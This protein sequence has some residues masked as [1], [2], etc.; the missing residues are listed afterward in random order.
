MEYR[1]FYAHLKENALPA[2]LL[3]HGEEEYIKESALKQ[4]RAAMLPEGLEVMNEVVFEG[5]AEENAIIEA[6]ET[7][8]FMAEK[9]LVLVRDHP[10][11]RN[12]QGGGGDGSRL[13][14]YLANMPD[15]AMLVFYVRG[16]A[17]M[18]RKVP[19][20]VA[21]AGGVVVFK[22]LEDRELFAFLGRECQRQGASLERG[23]AERLVFLCGRDLTVLSRE[24]EKAVAHAQDGKV[25][26]ADIDA[27]AI[28]NLEANVF[29][30]VDA[31]FD[32]ANARAEELLDRLLRDGESPIMILAVLT[33]NLRQLHHAKVV[34]DAH[35]PRAEAEKATGVSGF[36]AGRVLR[37]AERLDALWLGKMQ[38]MCA[39][40]DYEIKSGQ[41][42]E[43]AALDKVMFA[44][45][46]GNTP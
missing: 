23:A 35:R 12:G 7:L 44:L 46:R 5:A 38:A 4:L 9:R 3:M 8:P 21:K 31:V 37:R 13:T 39:A 24:V 29:Q 17:D 15:T 22:P 28:P 20:A 27:V 36:V 14:E 45:M 43:D 26:I 41:C 32:G 16:G 18:R 19:S 34:L 1:E 25:T 10:L 2:C 30:M 33:R 6:C 40:A 11:V 42:R